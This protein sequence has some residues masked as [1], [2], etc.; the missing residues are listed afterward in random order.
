MFITIST[1][2]YIKIQFTQ[3]QHICL[4]EMLKLEQWATTAF[5]KTYELHQKSWIH[6]QLWNC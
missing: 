5:Q 1:K 2:A 6:L 4:N 3:S